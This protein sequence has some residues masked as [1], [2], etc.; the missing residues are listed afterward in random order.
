MLSENSTLIIRSR[1][2]QSSWSQVGPYD[3]I[4]RGFRTQKADAPIIR[5]SGE[6]ELEVTKIERE[7]DLVI[8]SRVDEISYEF[9]LEV[10]EKSFLL[11][12]FLNI[13]HRTYLWSTLTLDIVQ[14][15]SGFTKG[16]IKKCV[17]KLPRSVNEAY[18]KI[19]ERS[20][21]IEK[22]R[23]LL[24]LILGA[25]RPLYLREI[26]LALALQKHHMHYTDVEEESG[27][28]F[29]RTV[30][31]L[32]GLFVT[33]VDNKIYLLHQTAREFLEQGEQTNDGEH[34]VVD[35]M[36][37]WKHSFRTARS[38]TVVAKIC[39]WYLR[40]CNG[41]NFQPILLEY[42]RD[43]WIEHYR[44]MDAQSR[45]A[46]A[47][48][49]LGLFQKDQPTFGKWCIFWQFRSRPIEPLCVAAWFGLESVA[50]LLLLDGNSVDCQDGRGFTPLI[51]AASQGQNEIV[52]L[53][54]F[55]GADVNFVADS[56]ALSWAAASGQRDTVVLLLESGADPNLTGLSGRSSLYEFVYSTSDCNIDIAEL[57]LAKGADV[58]AK[59]ERGYVPLH[60]A[61][62]Q[63]Q[64]QLVNLLL[65][66]GADVHS[67]DRKGLTPL[68]SAARSKR[69]PNSK[70]TVMKQLLKAGAKINTKSLDGW[71]S[72]IQAANNHDYLTV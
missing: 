53:L 26:S 54:L 63:G 14:N 18:E 60:A 22:T 39:I 46:L 27:L 47:G 5:L 42:A 59:T 51:Y 16:N 69:D 43:H 13:P 62:D 3:F 50:Q 66:N 71:T 4:L 38:N 20:R 72:L 15:L 21:D 31:D 11:E 8:R 35:N 25:K 36:S 58:N 2:Q 23:R 55:Y 1:P 37:Y 6:D 44:N 34:H 19:L 57:L 7:I 9:N 28:R 52:K 10:E 41:A 30:R 24:H 48:L 33:I 70:N 32:C 65:A 64:A 17:N 40:L 56:M 29:K 12:Q 67:R 49:V 61:A 68:E 45:N